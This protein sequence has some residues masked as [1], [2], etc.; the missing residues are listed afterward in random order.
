M[1]N[2]FW[3]WHNHTIILIQSVIETC[4]F[5][6]YTFP[7]SYHAPHMEIVLKSYALGKLTY[8]LP[9]IRARKPFDVS[10]SRVRV[11]D[12]LYVNK[13]SEFIQSIFSVYV[14]FYH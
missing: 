9:P 11:L 6:G 10:Y 14:H 12:F 4:V 2:I 8:Q 7:M 13:L 1:N 3:A 5:L